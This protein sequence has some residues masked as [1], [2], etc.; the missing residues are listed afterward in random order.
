MAMTKH[1]VRWDEVKVGDLVDH[2]WP[3]YRYLDGSLT[4]ITSIEIDGSR[5]IFATQDGGGS[6]PVAGIIVV[7]RDI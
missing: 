6:S 5:V 1:T 2:P 4:E 7:T 3:K